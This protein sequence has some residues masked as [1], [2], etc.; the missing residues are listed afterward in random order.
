MRR[1]GFGLVEV[2]VAISLLATVGGV[3]LVHMGQV[4]QAGR[5]SESGE[6][7]AALIQAAALTLRQGV[8]P[9][10]PQPNPSNPSQTTKTDLTPAQIAQL[11]NASPNKTY[12][13]PTIYSKVTVERIPNGALTNYKFTVCLKLSQANLCPSQTFTTPTANT[14]YVTPDS[15]STQNTPPKVTG[16]LQLSLTGPEGASPSVALNGP[17]TDTFTS[18]GV[19]TRNLVPGNYTLQAANT[20]TSRYSF[21]PDISSAPF[22]ITA[23]RGQSVSITYRCLTGAADITLTLPPDTSPDEAQVLLGSTRIT[24]SGI[25]PF[26]N[27]ATYNLTAKQVVKGGYTYTP[28][29]TPSALTITPCA[30]AGGSVNYLP[31]DGRAEV[32]VSVPSGVSTRPTVTLQGPTTLRQTGTGTLAFDQLPPGNYSLMGAEIRENGISYSA[33]AL[34]TTLSVSAG[35]T[36]NASL[37]YAAA[38]GAIQLTLESPATTDVTVA[39]AN[40]T[41]PGSYTIGYLAPGS[42]PVTAK[43]VY[44]SNFRYDPTPQNPT[45][46][47][48]AGTITPLTIRYTATAGS[49]TVNATLPPNTTCS[50]C[51]TVQSDSGATVAKLSGSGT[52]PYLSPGNYTVAPAVLTDASGYTWAASPVTVRVD[53]GQASTASIIYV[54]QSA[55]LT[56]NLSGLPNSA[57][58]TVTLSGPSGQTFTLAAGQTKTLS[59]L[60]LGTYTLSGTDWYSGGIRYQAAT[61]NLNLNTPGPKSATLM[62]S[63]ISGILQV[64][65]NGLPPAYINYPVQG[66][67]TYRVTAPSV[68]FNDVR[69][70]YYTAN[71]PTLR[72]NDP[73]DANVYYIYT[74]SA[75][76]TLVTGGSTG[77]LTV[78]YSATSSLKVVIYGAPTVNVSLSGGASATY[79]TPGT[80]YLNN[81]TPG[82]VNLSARPVTIGG[83]QYIPTPSAQSYTLAA[84][85]YITISVRYVPENKAV[86]DIRV[87]RSGGYSDSRFNPSQ[88]PALSI[89]GPS[90]TVASAS[91]TNSPLAVQVTSGVAYNGNLSP[92]YRYE[93]AN[94]CS[95]WGCTERLY[96][97]LTSVYGLPTTPSPGQTVSISINWAAVRCYQSWF[98]WS[99]YYVN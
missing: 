62:Y 74:P 95:M 24:Q 45:V 16:M 94:S 63:A 84:G 19:F 18:F 92:G 50:G 3:I 77:N 20:T 26:L 61:V 8:P 5:S 21:S 81:L 49:L 14:A 98:F 99:C 71:A 90:G 32:S 23:G 70:G 44:A 67:T 29:I 15:P 65:T 27:P 59:N 4:S 7:A 47:V 2:L 79:S 83:I 1:R 85:S 57:S 10:L 39:G 38:T 35:K 11:L 87:N 37:T 88:I 56:V 89:S 53:P 43:P 86:L 36:T 28:R 51:I 30:T 75:A 66:P 76:T 34:P 9:W 96:W 97:E 52:V 22:S 80:Y 48:Q 64:T 42:Y 33:T 73:S 6:A 93:F 12:T 78:N 60:K 41:A 69:T 82:T 46:N 68:T 17:Q 55:D 54:K 25:L 13:D 72:I 58:V 31:I 91:Y 40:Y